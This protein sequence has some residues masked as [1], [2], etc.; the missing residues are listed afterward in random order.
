MAYVSSWLQADIQRGA[1]RG[2]L[3]ARKQTLANRV[4]EPAPLMSGYRSKADVGGD[5]DL[6]PVMTQSSHRLDSDSMAAFGQE[7]PFLGFVSK[8]RLRIRGQPFEGDGEDSEK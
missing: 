1:V 8:I 5:A 2:L 3:S 6:R 4:S 7:R